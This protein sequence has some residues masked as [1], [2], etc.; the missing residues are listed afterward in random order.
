MVLQL[1]GF[2]VV[3]VGGVVPVWFTAVSIVEAGQSLS[4]SVV[5]GATRA[6]AG[7]TALIAGAG[8]LSLVS[9]VSAALRVVVVRVQEFGCSRLYLSLF[10]RVFE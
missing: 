4:A 5:S 8:E 2:C 3:G 1:S 9:M 10:A 7:C 6:S